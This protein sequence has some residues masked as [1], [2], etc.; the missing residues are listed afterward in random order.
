VS[1]LGYPLELACRLVLLLWC[2]NRNHAN[3]I[4]GTFFTDHWVLE[5]EGKFPLW[6]QLE[7]SK[8]PT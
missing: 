3:R 7:T 4:L 8:H 1:T 6:V 2:L 5:V